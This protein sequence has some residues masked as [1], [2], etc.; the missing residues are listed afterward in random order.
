M[1]FVV[2][3]VSSLLVENV[4]FR[5]KRG[6][7]NEVEGNYFRTE[8]NYVLRILLKYFITNFTIQL[9]LVKVNTQRYRVRIPVG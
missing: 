4:S 6:F 5:I 3:N 7:R 1:V 8:D 2:K 9:H